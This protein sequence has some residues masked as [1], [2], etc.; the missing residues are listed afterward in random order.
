[1]LLCAHLFGEDQSNGDDSCCSFEPCL[2]DLTFYSPPSQD[3]AV[4]PKS[5][6]SDRGSGVCRD[7]RCQRIVTAHTKCCSISAEPSRGSKPSPLVVTWTVEAA[8]NQVLSN[9]YHEWILEHLSFAF[10]VQ[11]LGIC[12]FIWILSVRMRIIYAESK[13]RL[14]LGSVVV[15]VYTD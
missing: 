3:E 12:C 14:K 15:S 10:D 8:E 4:E 9:M 2:D 7:R 6:Y 5:K 13:A 11:I 1:M